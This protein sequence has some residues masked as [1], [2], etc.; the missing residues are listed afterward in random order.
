MPLTCIRFFLRF[1][2]SRSVRFNRVFCFSN[3]TAFQ[4]ALHPDDRVA[5]LARVRA[6]LEQRTP[7]DMSCRLACGPDTYRWFRLR[8]LAERDAAGRPKRL[9]GSIRDISGQIDAEQALHR[10]E[11]FYRTVL[12]ANVATIGER[13]GVAA[14]K[15]YIGFLGELPGRSTVL[16]ST[17]L[18]DTRRALEL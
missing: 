11:D 16:R 14:T 15:R 6:Q 18:D 8:A 10:S 5:V 2:Y 9:S 12:D 4:K 17:T 3:F 1:A 13:D 7:L